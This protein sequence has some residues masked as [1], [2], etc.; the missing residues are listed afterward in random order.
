[1]KEL[2]VIWTACFKHYL[3]SATS[4]RQSTTFRTLKKFPSVSNASSLICKINLKTTKQSE[5]FSYSAHLVGIENRETCNRMQVNSNLCWLMFLKML[6]KVHLRK[7]NFNG[8]FMDSEK[9][10]LS[11]TTSILRALVKR[12]FH[13]SK[14]IY[15]NQIQSKTQSE[16]YSKQKT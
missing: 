6:W 2:L 1:M 8:Y 15:W 16:N 10:W 5:R 9:V 7:E 11:A 12:L 14:Y 4:E 13:K 3:Q